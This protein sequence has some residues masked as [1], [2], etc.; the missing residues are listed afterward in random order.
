M[1]KA[2][3]IPIRP[4]CAIKGFFPPKP[5]QKYGAMCG[6]VG[7][8]GRSCYYEGECVHQRAPQEAKQGEQ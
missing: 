2:K 5:G 8:G 7:V 3:T 1:D 6:K 4:S